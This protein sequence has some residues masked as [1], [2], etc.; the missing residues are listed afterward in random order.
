[1]LPLIQKPITGRE[2]ISNMRE[3]KAALVVFYC[4]FN[5][6]DLA[7]METNWDGSGQAVMDNPLGG[8]QRGWPEIR[9]LYERI[10]GAPTRITVELHDYTLHRKGNVFWVIGRERGRLI[11]TNQ[12]L[13]LA[14]RTTRLFRWDGKAWRQLHH[15]GSI[16]DPP[17]LCRYQAAFG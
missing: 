17:L 12:E 10:F 2:T 16:D 6:R 15:H 9:K 11:Q 3:P 14:I 13:D 8:I 7:L 5:S 4:A 1:M